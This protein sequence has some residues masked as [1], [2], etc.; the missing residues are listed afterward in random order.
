MKKTSIRLLSILSMLLLIWAGWTVWNNALRAPS[1][2]RL[3]LPPSLIAAD[4]SAGQKLFVSSQYTADYDALITH[5]VAQ[6]RPAFCGVASSVVVLNAINPALKPALKI[7]PSPTEN[8]VTQSTF[9]D[10]AARQVRGEFDVT[11]GGMSLAQLRD[12]LKAH[13]VDATLTYASDTTL[14]AFRKQAQENLKTPGDFILV[15]YQRGALGQKES[16]HISPLA[17]YHEASDRFLILDVAAYK[18]PPVWVSAQA[19]WAAMNTVD[20]SSGHTRGFVVV[21]PLPVSRLPAPAT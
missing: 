17:A 5:F 2:N 1:F 20:Q 12:L 15:N 8:P 21:K 7:A 14:E 4:S 6:A 10:A 18:Y 13:G 19:L 16:G 3:P 11:F 9:F